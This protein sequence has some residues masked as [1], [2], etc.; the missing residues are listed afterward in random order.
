MA[1]AQ[2][3]QSSS[4]RRFAG[5]FAGSDVGNSNEEEAVGKFR[6]MRRMALLENSRIIDLLERPDVRKAIDDQMQPV[7]QDGSALQEAL[8]A[9][10][11]LTNE[12]TERMRDVQ[13]LAELARIKGAEAA[14][15][16]EE[17]ALVLSQTG[18]N[19]SASAHP[20]AASQAV[21]FGAQGRLFEGAVIVLAC[22]LAVTAIFKGVFFE[23]S[24]SHGMADGQRV[25]SPLVRQGRPILHVP[26][27]RSL[28]R[29]M[30][31]D[32]A[33]PGAR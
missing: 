12:L 2:Q 22:L 31:R 24:N 11:A 5:L 14:E 9:C 27:H 10:T 28:P 29:R 20:P 32:G 4:A 17:L 16:R 13:R 18:R 6:A 8:E 1:T 26:K 19:P 30:H 33:T 3:S 23:R 15:L 25:A 21:S 7:R